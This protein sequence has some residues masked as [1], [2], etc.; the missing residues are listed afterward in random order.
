MAF[1]QGTP[2]FY[3]TIFAYQMPRA[4]LLGGGAP[5]LWDKTLSCLVN[6]AN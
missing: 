1:C 2:F 3:S 4:W 6:L 5:N